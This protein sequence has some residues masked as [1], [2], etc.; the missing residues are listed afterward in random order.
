MRALGNHHLLSLTVGERLY[1]PIFQFSNAHHLNRL[2]NDGLVLNSEF[3]PKARIRHTAHPHHLRHTEILNIGLIGQ[4]N[5]DELRPLARRQP[6]NI[7][8]VEQ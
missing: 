2:R 5:A 6:V 7:P 4:H 1:H 3:S 8:S